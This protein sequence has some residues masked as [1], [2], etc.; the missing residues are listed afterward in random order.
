MEFLNK[1][2]EVYCRESKWTL[3]N[4][5]PMIRI[6]A[7][8]AVFAYSKEN[9]TVA[10]AHLAEIE[11]RRSTIKGLGGRGEFGH[12]IPCHINTF[13]KCRTRSW[14]PGYIVGYII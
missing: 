2:D 12:K 11:A 5:F 7:I 6:H 1:L 10:F 9:F 13:I 4:A 3:E 14:G 8:H